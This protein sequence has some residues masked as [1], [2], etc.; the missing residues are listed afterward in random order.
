MYDT[1]FLPLARQDMIDIVRYI[2]KELS[3]PKAADRLAVELTE[4]VDG[5]SV[6]P[7][8]CPAY[9]PLRPLKHEFRKLS[10]QNY[11]IFYWVDEEKKRVTVA[12]VIYAKR[13]YERLLE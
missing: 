9:I 3:S 5:L 2:S 12:R 8:A 4:A 1:V 7:Y 13:E 6:F 11:L 10:V